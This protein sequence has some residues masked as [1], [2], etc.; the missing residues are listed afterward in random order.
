[1]NAPCRLGIDQPYGLCSVWWYTSRGVSTPKP[2]TRMETGTVTDPFAAPAAIPSEYPT[3][4]S[5]RGRLVLIRPIKI[6][7]VP[8]TQGAPGQM[9]DRVT[10]DVTVVDGLGPVPGFTRGQPNG[11]SFAGPEFRGTYISQEVIVKQLADVTPPRGNGMVLARIDTKT[12]GTAPGKGNPWGLI[13]P[14]DQDRD[15]ARAFLANRTVNGAS[16]PAPVPVATP[17]VPSPAT[18]PQPV[19]QAVYAAPPAAPAVPAPGSAPAGMN[20]FA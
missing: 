14:T 18:A 20:P 5:F 8:N 9:Q 13:H 7:T 15:I 19:Q 12:P 17:G 1:M 11:Q 3:V 2:N 10:A 6:E 16:A 4:A